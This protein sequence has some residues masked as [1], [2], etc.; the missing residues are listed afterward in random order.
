[1]ADD[2]L[3]AELVRW[4]VAPIGRRPGKLPQRSPV[5]CRCADVTAAEIT[6]DLA[7]GASLAAL[8]ERR[9]CGT[10]CGS[11]LPELRQ[12]VAAHASDTPGARAA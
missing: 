4:A 3:D 5:V 10:F 1:M 9:G 7:S 8:Q 2:S 6:A 12:M 11:C